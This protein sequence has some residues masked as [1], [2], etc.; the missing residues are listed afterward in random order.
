MEKSDPNEPAAA[1]QTSDGQAVRRRQ[2]AGP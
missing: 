1:V 2:E